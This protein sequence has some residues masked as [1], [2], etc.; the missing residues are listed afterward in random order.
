M[1]S[2]DGG[3]PV[4]S[5]RRC[6][7]RDAIASGKRRND[8]DGAVFPTQ[9][10]L[11]TLKYLSKRAGSFCP[12]LASSR[13]YGAPAP[14]RATSL[15]GKQKIHSQRFHLNLTGSKMFHPEVAETEIKLG[16]V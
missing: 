6:A 16:A 14:L 2:F 4:H 10:S 9:E 11:I 12:P 15:V 7:Q 3:N 13:A 1:K 5:A 8:A